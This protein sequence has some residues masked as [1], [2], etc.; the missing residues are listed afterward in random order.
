M[1]QRPFRRAA[2]ASLAAVLL[3]AGVASADSVRADGDIV[4]PGNQTLVDLGKVAPSA[5]VSAE[6]AFQL[7]CGHLS[8]VD[9]GQTVTLGWS[10][11]QAPGDGEIISVTDATVGPIPDGWTVDG[12]GCVEPAPTL[13]GGS[14]ST[15]TLQAPSTPGAGYLFVVMWG[16]SLSPVG[17]ADGSAFASS[18]TALTFELEVVG[19]TPPVLAVPGDTT[20]EGDTTGGWTADWSGVSATDAEDDPDPTPTC[21]PAGGGLVPL[22]TTTVECSV[23]DTAGQSDSGT[24]DVT[25]VDTTAPALVGMPADQVVTT[26]DP[27]GTTLD[28]A[29]PGATDVVDPAP[30]VRCL[31]AAGAQLGLGTTTVTCTATDASGNTLSDTFDVVVSYRA[32]HAASAT[33]L[34]PVGSAAVLEANRGRNVPIKVQL[35]VD[36][37][38]RRAGDASLTIGPCGAG[39]ASVIELGYSGG[40]WNASLDTARLTGVCYTVGVSIDGLA[41]GAFTLEL[42]GTEAATTGAKTRTSRR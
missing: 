23:T 22:G 1:N 9:A 14:T 13:G 24:F 27:S 5:V 29:P 37:V 39:D 32:P 30:A 3:F 16:R 20:V 17:D 18:S 12:E 4:A 6:V 35:F 40:R 2:A 33:W 15:V 36:G 34:E 21:T 26:S 38:E 28:Y 8:H 19:D 10:T 41:A 31:P 25:I 42:R 11:G 7:I